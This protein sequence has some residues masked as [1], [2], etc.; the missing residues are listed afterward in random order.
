[1]NEFLT[2]NDAAKVLRKA[3]STVILYE[4][5]GKLA[6]MRTQGG[7]RLFLRHDVER[8]AAEQE[9]KMKEAS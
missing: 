2:T 9:R 7:V 6:A 8:L 3:P 4:K 5:Q 1:M